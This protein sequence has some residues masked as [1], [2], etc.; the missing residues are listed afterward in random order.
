MN[1]SMR[2]VSSKLASPLMVL[3]LLASSGC[4][5]HE[6]RPQPRLNA[7]QAAEEIPEAQLLDVG[8]RL[9]DENVPEDEKKREKE[10]IFPDVRKAE[11]RYLAMQVRNTLEGSG[12]WGQVRVI[13]VDDEALDV[14]VS[15]KILESTGMMLRL[16]VTVDDATG[17]VWFQKE[18]EQLA[19]TRSYKDTTGKPRDPFQNLYA[20]LANDILAHR[21]TLVAADLETIRN[22][23]ELRFARDLAPY[24]FESYLGTDKKKGTY[25]VLR[26]PSSDDPML[27]RM[28]RIRERDYALLDTVNE[29]Y[30]LF[31]DNM[32][33]SY[34]NWRRYS[35]DEIEAHD[36]A[37]RSATTRKLLGA[38]AIIGGLV[39]GTQS[40][41]YVGQAAATAGVFGGAYA[42]KSGFDKGA[43]VKMHSDSLKQLG[44]SFQAEIQP[45][46]VEVEGRT[47]QLRGTAEEQYQEWRRLL[48][49]LYENETGL[50]VVTAPVADGQAAAPTANA[51][52]GTR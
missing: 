45:M 42:V 1:G 12:Q 46:V 8:V 28:D 49:E 10:R 27:V 13:P 29:H 48:K 37:Q 40:N 51:G 14:R 11:A 2:Q 17:R 15:A 39:M 21:Q 52:G 44:E 41:T 33:E 30:A 9:F 25:Q 18:Y 32:S 20:T 4:V 5:T 50:P 31:T 26:L 43:E 23:S 16:A 36:E 35:H 24:A 34:T 22:V 3:A 47:L 19:D 6:T 38:A 7:I